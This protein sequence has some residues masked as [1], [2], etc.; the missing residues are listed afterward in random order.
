M[1]TLLNYPLNKENA[2]L[3]TCAFYFYYHVPS[4]QPSEFP[5]SDPMLTLSD[6]SSN[7][8]PSIMNFLKTD[9]KHITAIISDNG[10]GMDSATLK[11]IRQSLLDH[12]PAQ[13]HIG[14][15]NIHIRYQILYGE[16]FGISNIQSDE[17]GTTIVLRIPL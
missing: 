4:I 1:S 15:K 5:I 13:K 11:S 16:E 7:F 17:N 12:E 14:I 9:D 8:I 3:K 6:T 10:K 2:S